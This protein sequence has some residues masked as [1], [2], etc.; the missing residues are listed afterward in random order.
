MVFRAGIPWRLHAS[1]STLCLL[2]T[3]FSRLDPVEWRAAVPA[4]GVDDANLLAA[5]LTNFE[6]HHDILRDCL[7]L[8]SLQPVTERRSHVARM[9]SGRRHDCRCC[10]S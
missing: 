2:R 5:V 8:S 7:I 6:W 4:V 9:Q 10:L 1:L 3:L